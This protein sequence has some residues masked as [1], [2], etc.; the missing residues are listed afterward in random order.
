MKGIKGFQ[1]GYTP[2]NKGKK[3]S[4]PSLKGRI[5]W[6]KGKKGLQV[7]TEEAKEKFRRSM[8]GKRWTLSEE[9]KK[10]FSILRKGKPLSPEHAAKIRLIKV[11]KIKEKIGYRGVHAWIVLRHGQ[12]RRCE[13]CGKDGLTGRQIHWANISDKYSRDRSDWRRLCAKCHKAF[14][15]LKRN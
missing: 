9:T 4:M 2:W 6:N 11:G 5:P 3:V 1:K 14:D 12:P 8:V 13:E 7:R 10:K 15:R